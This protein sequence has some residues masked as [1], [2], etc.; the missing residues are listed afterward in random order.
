M[1]SSQTRLLRIAAFLVDALTI[2]LILILPGAAVSYG[3]TWSGNPR[4]IQMVWWVALAILMLAMLIRDGFR[5]RSIGK[6]LLG[7]RLLTPSGEGCGW[8]RS[9]VRN[10]PLLIPVWNLVEVVMVLMGK[11][12]T[13]DRIARTQVTEE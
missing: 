1:D 8:F 11:A 3:L 12:R 6:Q 7:L 10:L 2:S 13:G 5:G 4:G 9:L